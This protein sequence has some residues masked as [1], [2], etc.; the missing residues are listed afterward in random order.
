M[1]LGPGKPGVGN[2]VNQL[3][4][5]LN[6]DIP[7]STMLY[8]NKI[9]SSEDCADYARRK[10][11]DIKGRESVYAMYLNDRY[12]V[13]LFT[14]INTSNYRET[15]FNVREALKVALFL[16]FDHVILF[17]N[18]T[19]G[20]ALPSEIDKQITLYLQEIFAAVDINLTDHIILTVNDHYSFA[21]NKLLKTG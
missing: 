12:E 4:P 19:S 17:H 1:L 9:L 6:G 18:H 7:I 2:S 11:V 8:T 3:R 20:I 16:N 14:Q 5:F 15:N 10:W 21:D 13:Q